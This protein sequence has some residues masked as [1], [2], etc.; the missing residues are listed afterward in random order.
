MLRVERPYH[1]AR[2]AHLALDAA[3]RR[4]NALFAPLFEKIVEIILDVMAAAIPTTETIA[5]AFI[6]VAALVC[7]LIQPGAAAENRQLKFV[8][9]L[10]LHANLAIVAGTPKIVDVLAGDC[11]NRYKDKSH[12]TKGFFG[13]IL[14]NLPDA[15]IVTDAQYI[16]VSLNA[17]FERI[18]QHEP[19]TGDIR[20][21]FKQ[22][23]LVGD[24][25]QLWNQKTHC[26]LIRMQKP[27][28]T[29]H[30]EIN[31]TALAHNFVFTAKDKTQMVCY[32]ELIKEE[33]ANSDK[34]LASIL[35]PSLVP[36]VQAGE[37][38]ISFSVQSASVLFIDIV[39]FTPWCASNSA[40]VVMS[41]LNAL[42]RE[43][44]AICGS[45]AKLS[46][47]KCIGD[48]YMAAAG[49]FSEV[50]QPAGTQRRWPSLG[51]SG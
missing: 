47:I 2:V 9:R 13:E 24:F 10:L 46:K 7:I 4:R 23:Q 31:V 11:L 36:L 1:V 29:S 30:L 27:S 12:H 5:I 49:I 8:L 51:S 41:S 50:N 17:A 21:F 14:H 35:P 43:L 28:L 16:V 32:N 6:I 15:V 26:V 19:I 38:N 20:D 33:R 45:K 25:E 3:N 39:E 40:S 37:V 34:M 44:D 48:C 42:Y 22:P 18:D